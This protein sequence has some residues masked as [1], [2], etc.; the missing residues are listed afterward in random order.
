V[1]PERLESKQLLWDL[2]D[3][4]YT[5]PP[6]VPAALPAHVVKFDEFELDCN[7]YQL[8]RGGRPIKLEKL[9]MELLILLLDREGH[10]VTRDEI[11]DRLWGPGVFLDTEHGINTAIR[12]IRHVLRDDAERPRFVQTITG[13]GYRF[14]APFNLEEKSGTSTVPLSAAQPGR[15]VSP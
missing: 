1:K 10:L 7:R 13:K 4:C 3:R 6:D 12:K 9:P 11:V 5:P 14:V 8:F 2:S 15:A